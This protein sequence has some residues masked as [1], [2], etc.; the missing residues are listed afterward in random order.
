MIL[1]ATVLQ[2]LYKPGDL[3][4]PA[5]WLGTM[6][7]VAT[8]KSLYGVIAEGDLYYMLF[9]AYGFMVCLL[10]FKLEA[11]AHSLLQYFFGLLPSK[12]FACF[13]VGITT[14]GTSARSKSEFTRPESF[15]SR[16]THI[17]Q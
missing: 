4:R 14:W 15:Y 17:G 16:T 9:G 10:F 8:I 5:I 1:T 11:S 7:G 3:I 2:M 12:L 6:F 13:T